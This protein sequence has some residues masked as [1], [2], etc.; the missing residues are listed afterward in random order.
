MLYKKD[1]PVPA[2]RRAPLREIVELPAFR[3]G[4]LLE[5]GH[6]ARDVRHGQFRSR[7][8]DCLRKLHV[9]ID[10]QRTKL[11]LRTQRGIRKQ[12]WEKISKKFSGSTRGF[13]II[14]G[15]KNILD[16]AIIDGEKELLLMAADE[17]GLLDL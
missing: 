12:P 15:I 11:I 5:C 9:T 13:W 3:Y 7:C 2:P 8:Q 4:A 16:I 17:I 6:T 10:R 1:K 14:A